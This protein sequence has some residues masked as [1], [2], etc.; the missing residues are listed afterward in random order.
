M[1]WSAQGNITDKSYIHLHQQ[2]GNPA[3]FIFHLFPK[4]KYRNR[5]NLTG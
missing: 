5:N 3:C 4:N 2:A 1:F